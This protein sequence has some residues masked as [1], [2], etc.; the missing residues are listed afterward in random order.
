MKLNAKRDGV[1]LKSLKHKMRPLR[2]QD[3]DERVALQQAEQ[4]ELDQALGMTTAMPDVPTA[5]QEKTK[6][7]GLLQQPVPL[8]QL[9]P[10]AAPP[11]PEAPPQLPL[12]PALTG[13]QPAASSN[14]DDFEDDFSARYNLR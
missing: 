10:Q 9:Q 13:V 3:F 4:C 5:L 14:D 8:P 12:A 7:R 1:S 2:P 11:Q 6:A